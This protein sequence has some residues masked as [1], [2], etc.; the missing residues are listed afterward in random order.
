MLIL[1]GAAS[2]SLSPRLLLWG[3]GG[4]VVG[5]VIGCLGGGLPAAE[6]LAALAVA[7]VALLL[8][9]RQR[10]G[11]APALELCGALIAGAMAL[12]ALLHAQEVPDQ[13]S[14]SLWWMGV[15]FASGVVSLGSFALWQRLCGPW[16]Q[17]V[18]WAFALT[19]GWLMMS[20]SGLMS[21]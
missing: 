15:C 4:G 6:P 3:L 10:T 14:A 8:V 18:S 5:A 19:S 20:S 17:R 2:A 21:R 1:L 11:Q 16:P 13:T 9:R 12:H 7:A